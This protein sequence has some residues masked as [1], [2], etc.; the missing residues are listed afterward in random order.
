[1]F[2]LWGPITSD[3]LCSKTHYIIRIWKPINSVHT[4]GNIER[5]GFTRDICQHP[6]ENRQK[7]G[8]FWASPTPFTMHPICTLLSLFNCV[9]NDFCSHGTSDD[10]AEKAMDNPEDS[11]VLW[12]AKGFPNWHRGKHLSEKS[13]CP[14]NFC[15]QFWGRNGCANF[16]GAWKKCVRSAGKAMSI[17]FLVLGG[18]GIS[19]LGGGGEVPILFLWARGF[20]WI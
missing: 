2:K 8:L 19:G 9:A 20:F 6:P 12:G 10:V 4:R 11:K 16:M 7:S 5:Q 13:S 17:K 18:G 1:M 14:Q 3:T 15:P